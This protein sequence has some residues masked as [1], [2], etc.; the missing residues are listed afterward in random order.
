MITS[1]FKRFFKWPEISDDVTQNRRVSLLHVFSNLVIILGSLF[2]ISTLFFAGL[3]LCL[4]LISISIVLY[5]VLTRVMLLRGKISFASI[6]L[7]V[8]GMIIV[9]VS[10]VVLGG[11][12]TPIAALYL[13]IIIVGGIEYGLAAVIPLSVISSFLVALSLWFFQTYDLAFPE[14]SSL[15]VSGLLYGVIF[16]MGGFLV[17]FAIRSASEA[18]NH[19]RKEIAERKVVEQKL[20]ESEKQYRNL[21]EQTHDAVIILGLDCKIITA[22]PR[23]AEMTGYSIEEFLNIPR[24]AISLGQAKETR[25]MERLLAGEKVPHFEEQFRKKDGSVIF[26]EIYLELIRD[27]ENRPSRLQMVVRDICERRLV[28]EKLRITNEQ[29]NR[30]IEEIEKL[31]QKLRDQVIRDPLTGLFN[32][33][34]LTETLFREIA[35]SKRDRLRMSLLVLDL[36]HF[37]NIN[38]AYGHTAGD[39]CL[40]DIARRLVSFTR[41]SDMVCRYGGEEFVI[42]MG[43]ASVSDAFQRS[44]EIRNM[45]ESQPI[46][47]QEEVFR[48]TVSIGLASYPDHGLSPEELIARADM[49]M[50]QSK[51]AGRNRVSIYSANENKQPPL[52]QMPTSDNTE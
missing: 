34:Y 50:Y 15:V 52:R 9:T 5:G 35:R 39:Y 38:D 26:V 51:Q 23:A 45:I 10:I 48:L 30:R 11:T 19:A 25:V 36:D 49:A 40:M 1:V 42:V 18:L 4:R 21:F 12:E 41:E 14:Y 8:V 46:Y 2:F 44:E 47:Y 37:K 33:R 7:L 28:E 29:L 17:N 13:I 31:Q 20:R 22:N 6:W 3:N 27:D 43:N 32:R 24:E 16:I